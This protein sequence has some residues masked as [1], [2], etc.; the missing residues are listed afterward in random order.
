[1]VYRDAVLESH[2]PI[3]VDFFLCYFPSSS[4][5][6]VGPKIQKVSN[7]RNL[8]QGHSPLTT[9]PVISE[10]RGPWDVAVPRVD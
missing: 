2:M 4:A 3:H 8:I 10:I 5:P 1:M 9:D 6:H 7:F